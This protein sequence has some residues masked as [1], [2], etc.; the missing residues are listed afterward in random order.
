VRLVRTVFTNWES[1]SMN[2]FFSLAAL[3]ITAMAFAGVLAQ[4]LAAQ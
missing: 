4:P 1:Y 3:S 2:K